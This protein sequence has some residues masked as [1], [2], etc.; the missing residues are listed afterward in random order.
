MEKE[1]KLCPLQNLFGWPEIQAFDPKGH[2]PRI[3]VPIPIVK[4]FVLRVP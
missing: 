3:N 1:P 2:T 4:V